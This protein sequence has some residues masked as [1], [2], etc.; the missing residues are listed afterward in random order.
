MAEFLIGVAGSLAATALLMAV[1][2]L[3][4]SRARRWVLAAFARSAGLG[5]QRIHLH[6][7]SASADL[8]AEAARAGWVG[9]LAGRGNELTRDTFL[10]LWSD[11]GWQPRP[12]RILLPDPEP[13]HDTWLVRRQEEV[14][15]GDPGLRTGLLAEQVR[16]NARYLAS[17]ARGKENCEIRF[18]DLPNHFRVVITERTA[19][20]TIYQSS[21]HGRKSPC[22]VARR[23]GQIYD[24]A[25]RIFSS[26]WESGRVPS[27]TD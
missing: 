20:L 7:K 12:I 26:A 5:V 6:Q 19:F 11:A 4:S 13:G 21:V 8:A 14:R 25:Q 16:I 1:G 2:W 17:A 22:I 3:L 15:A 9:V 18:Y 24:F 23:P 27:T 10:P